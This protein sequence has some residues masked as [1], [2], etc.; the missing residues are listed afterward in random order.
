[1]VSFTIIFSVSWLG[2]SVDLK[3]VESHHPVVAI[4]LSVFFPL[5]SYKRFQKFDDKRV[6][7]FCNTTRSVKRQLFQTNQLISVLES[8]KGF[9]RTTDVNVICE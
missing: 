4:S 1:M 8:R 9:M 5:V 2:Q 7:L 6:T 3:V